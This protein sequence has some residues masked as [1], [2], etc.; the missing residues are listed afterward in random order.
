MR[1]HQ[2]LLLAVC[3]L[4]AC[5]VQ[6]QDQPASTN[7]KDTVFVVQRDTIY[8][9]SRDTIYLQSDEEPTRADYYRDVD[10]RTKAE[11]HRA[12]LKAEREQRAAAREAL[13]DVRINDN[14]WSYQVVASRLLDPHLSVLTFGAVNVRKSQWGYAAY[15]GVVL[16]SNLRETDDFERSP[17]SRNTFAGFDLGLEARHYISD[18]NDDEP[19]YFG[20]GV[21]GATA[22]WE[23]E[24]YVPNAAG[25]FQEFRSADSDLRRLEFSA[26]IGW[27]ARL[28]N[29]FV[30]DIALGVDVGFLG[31]FTDDEA[32]AQDLRTEQVTEPRIGI[33]EYAP[34]THF[35]VRIGLGLGSW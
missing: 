19:M 27:D 15:G 8:A 29:G 30:L 18:L 13:P 33:N 16:G 12:E 3:L 2:S 20:A 24:R 25:T 26:L 11:Q 35:L 21:S 14:A 34:Y 31:V 5:F 7:A 10:S 32:I 28:E 17:R 9:V 22:A 4:A 6:A 1:V 23:H